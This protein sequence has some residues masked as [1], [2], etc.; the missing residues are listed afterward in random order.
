LCIGQKGA[1]IGVTVTGTGTREIDRLHFSVG[2]QGG[3]VAMGDSIT[4]KV[5]LS[6]PVRTALLLDDLTGQLG[7]FAEGYDSSG[8]L[9]GSTSVVMVQVGRDEH[10]EVIL[11]FAFF[12]QTDGGLPDGPF[13]L[14]GLPPSV[15][16]SVDGITHCPSDTDLDCETFAGTPD[17]GA[18]GC[19]I[20]DTIDVT[21]SPQGWSGNYLE[22]AS[23]MID[24]PTC[25]LTRSLPSISTGQ[26]WARFYVYGEM[27]SPSASIQFFVF[28]DEADISR[29]VEIDPKGSTLNWFVIGVTTSGTTYPPFTLNQWQ[30][31]EVQID[32]TSNTFNAYVDATGS[33]PP[34]AT[35][36]GVPIMPMVEFSMGVFNPQGQP[37]DVR[38][39]DLA[40]D[41]A[42]IGCE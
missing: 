11:P 23:T 20:P 28:T 15:D 41:T 34:F 17:L 19:G 30:C 25:V 7:V 12:G 2:P 27:V 22:I 35:A 13:V 8:T 3:S 24:G 5:P 6:F 37:F 33:S 21:S 36:T 4:S 42:R 14:D 29:G 39:D 31:V 32:Y 18:T 16:G 40:I 26:L 38:F 1:C 10:A 9:V